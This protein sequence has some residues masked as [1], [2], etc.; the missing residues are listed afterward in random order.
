MSI[1]KTK[2]NA[3]FT[4]IPLPLTALKRESPALRLR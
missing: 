4:G 3:A 2:K 1:W